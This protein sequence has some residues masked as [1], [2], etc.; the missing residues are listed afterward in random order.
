MISLALATSISKRILDA[1]TSELIVPIVYA[2]RF[3]LSVKK[4]AEAIRLT[5]SQVW[6]CA[7]YFLLMND[8]ST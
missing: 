8:L 7:N 3:G 1:N 4:V 2:I 6:F 5:A